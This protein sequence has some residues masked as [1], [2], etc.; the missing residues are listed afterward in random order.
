MFFFFNLTK[1]G[2]AQLQKF[3]SLLLINYLFNTGPSSKVFFFIYSKETTLSTLDY[4]YVYLRTIYCTYF[5]FSYYCKFYMFSSQEIILYLHLL[6]F[7][8][9]GKL[10][11]SK[12]L[13]A[14]VTDLFIFSDVFVFQNESHF[15]NL[16]VFNKDTL[17]WCCKW[18]EEGNYGNFILSCLLNWY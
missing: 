4:I 18:L 12:G 10:K 9:H 3:S 16:L 6:Y 15:L 17:F 8:S 13:V 5:R 11:P 7:D 14:M 2:S 1:F